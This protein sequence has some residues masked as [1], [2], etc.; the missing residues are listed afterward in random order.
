MPP[1]PVYFRF[2]EVNRQAG[3]KFRHNNGA[4]GAA[5]LP[6]TMGSGV[7]F[8][9]YD[10]DGWQDIFFVNG[11]N[12]TPTEVAAYKQSAI[13]REE[14]RFLMAR[15]ATRQTNRLA[16]LAR[17][18]PPN[19][20]YRR[21]VGALYHNNRDGTFRDVTRGSGLDIEMQGMGVAV[22][23][24]DNDGRPD[25]VV[26][27]YGRNY[28]FRNCSTNGRARFREEA[29]RAGVRDSGWCSCAA[30]LDYDND[31]R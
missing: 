15:Q 10:G 27:A 11:R 13:S 6:E 7:A 8:L 24:Y 12:W 29:V 31:G 21:T 26:T 5:F 22:G 20:P 17:Q 23:D 1:R 9:D 28:L 16:P 25:L 18:V 19:K 2:T 14:A 3:I 4:F 30:F